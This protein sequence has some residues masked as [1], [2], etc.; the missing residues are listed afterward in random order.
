MFFAVG[1]ARLGEHG[2]FGFFVSPMFPCRITASSPSGLPFSQ[3]TSQPSQ[4]EGEALGW[5]DRW[6][7]GP[8]QLS[9]PGGFVHEQAQAVDG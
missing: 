6:L 7:L 9:G 5:P 2:R 1:L 4:P 3:P 8:G